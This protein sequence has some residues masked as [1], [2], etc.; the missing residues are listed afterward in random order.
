ML[1]FMG[2]PYVDTRPY[3]ITRAIEVPQY[4]MCMSHAAYKDHK[5]EFRRTYRPH[6]SRA[7]VSSKASNKQ[8][9]DTE[10]IRRGHVLVAAPARTLTTTVHSTGPEK[11]MHSFLPA[12]RYGRYGTRARVGNE[13]NA[14]PS[15]R[16]FGFGLRG[17]D[18]QFSGLRVTCTY[19]ALISP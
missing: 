7:E 17:Y 15:A 8:K 18:E 2:S 11:C 6:H 12:I 5:D 1:L 13:P 16:S 9:R 19:F 4:H 10:H 3:A 14:P